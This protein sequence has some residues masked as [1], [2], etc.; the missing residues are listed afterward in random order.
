M[1][2]KNK[3]IINEIINVLLLE[4]LKK[5]YRIIFRKKYIKKY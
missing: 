5:I 1:N 4:E 2:E 3:R